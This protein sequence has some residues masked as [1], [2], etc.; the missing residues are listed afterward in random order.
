MPGPAAYHP[1][2]VS[3]A[4]RLPGGKFSTAKPLGPME[5]LIK[6]ARAIPGPGQYYV[7]GRTRFGDG[8][9]H[10]EPPRPH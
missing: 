7:T 3:A 4:D 10:F 2:P 5:R 9:A 1:E 6:N 8:K